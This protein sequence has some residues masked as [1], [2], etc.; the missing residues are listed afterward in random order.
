[1]FSKKKKKEESSVLDVLSLNI[2][3]SQ[4]YIYKK[5]SL[6]LLKKLTFN[7][8]NFVSSYINNKDVI[9]TTVKISKNIE[10]DDVADIIDI[11][12]YE[13]LGLDEA[14]SYN[15]VSVEAEED[16]DERAYHIFVTPTD[17]LDE[18]YLPV[19]KQIKYFDLIT[20]APLLYQ[21]LYTK[22]MLPDNKSHAFVYFTQND[23]FIT[24]YKNGKYIYSKSLEFS[25]EQIYD[26]YC[27]LIGEK[28]DENEFYSVLESEGLQTNREEF[29]DTFVKIFG[30][31]FIVINDIIIYAK[32]AFELESI[33]Q[34][35]IGSNKGPILGLDDY[36]QNYLG[37]NSTEFNLKYNI[38]NDDWYTDQLQYLM[39]LNS[40]QYIEDS[41]SFVNMTMYP[42]PPSFVNRASGQF[43]LITFSAIS[44]SLA[45]PLIFLVGAYA[46][47]AKVYALDIE[48]KKLTQESIKYKKIISDKKKI[49]KGLDIDVKRLSGKYNAKTKTLESI[50]NTKVNYRLK[51]GILHTVAEELTKFE[52]NIDRLQT[53]GDMI[54]L[55]LVSS[56]D[57][58]FTELIKY[59]SE[60]HFDEIVSINIDKIE[61][62]PVNNYYIGILKVELK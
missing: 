45:Y 61:K 35:F 50:Y 36:S 51:S 39:V 48:N 30:E 20:P 56:E 49:I 25:L 60:K 57:R 11:K 9:T 59:M 31:V 54:T 10:E 38:E 6:K 43:I 29:K 55:S 7:K 52:V 14:T 21:V 5:D 40:L 13:D 37:L 18:L 46:N 19:K 15:I 58:R 12:A 4:G 2:Y 26:R 17:R 53:K 28:I 47:N 1:M 41:S 16:A 22:E 8:N 34:I 33:E 27:E 62:D 32:R 3:N 23:T 24:I 44:A 42:R